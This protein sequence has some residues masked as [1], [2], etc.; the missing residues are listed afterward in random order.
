[1]EDPY[2]TLLNKMEVLEK[3][4]MDNEDEDYSKNLSYKGA[5]RGQQNRWNGSFAPIYNPWRRGYPNFS[6][7]HQG[8]AARPLGLQGFQQRPH[9]QPQPSTQDSSEDKFLD[10]LEQISL[11]L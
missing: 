3:I 5:Y 9:L 10:F 11:Q 7:S 2:A 4:L 8:A 6:W 1:M